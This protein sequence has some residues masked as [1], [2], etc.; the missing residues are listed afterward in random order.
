MNHTELHP[1]ER[2]PPPYPPILGVAVVVILLVLALAALKSYRDLQAARAHEAELQ[3]GI[4]AAEQRIAGL[5]ERAA[6]LESDP[7]TLER[8]A[9]E[10][11]GMIKPGDVVII[12]PTEG[13]PPLPAR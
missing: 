8:M 13:A 5:R 2:K 1:Q 4:R 11:L 12:L 7:L 9:R 10:E 3:Q 6:S